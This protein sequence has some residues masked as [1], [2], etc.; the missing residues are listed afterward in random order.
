[1][2]ES[3]EV[4]EPSSGIVKEDEDAVCRECNVSYEDDARN[5]IGEECNYQCSFTCSTPLIGTFYV[6]F[7]YC[8]IYPNM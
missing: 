8:F 3:D 6:C 5:G 7:T 2:S 1:M 4:M